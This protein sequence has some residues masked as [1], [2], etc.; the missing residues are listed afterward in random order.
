MEGSTVFHFVTGGVREAL[1]RAFEAAHG[2]DVQLGGGVSTIRQ[3]LEVRLIDEMHVAIAPLLL[4]SGEHLFA[5]LD[6]TAL[7]Y[8]CAEHVPSPNATHVVFRKREQ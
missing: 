1:D 6:L 7:G 3:Y 8:T 5:G 2:R 4:G